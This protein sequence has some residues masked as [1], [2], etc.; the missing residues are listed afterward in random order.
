MENKTHNEN[1]PL[2]RATF[3]VYTAIQRQ[4]RITK[5]S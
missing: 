3:H 5:A 4:D 1:M 2:V